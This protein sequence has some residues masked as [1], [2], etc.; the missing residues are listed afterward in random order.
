MCQYCGNTGLCYLFLALL[1]QKVYR[2]GKKGVLHLKNRGT[3]QRLKVS[4]GK[5]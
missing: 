1:S 3:Q 4:A 5:S 2:L